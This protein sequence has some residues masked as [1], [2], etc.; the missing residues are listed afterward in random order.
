MLKSMTNNVRLLLLPLHR[1]V[2]GMELEL[3]SHVQGQPVR[4]TH[5]SARGWQPSYC[6]SWG[7][8]RSPLSLCWEEPG[9]PQG[10]PELLTHTHRAPCEPGRCSCR[11]TPAQARCT[12]PLGTESE[13][14]LQF[15]P[16][17]ML[18]VNRES[19]AKNLRPSGE[20]RANTEVSL[21]S[22]EFTE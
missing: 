11:G 7:L 16:I 15:K 20:T 14:R 8:S 21:A 22:T 3:P 9:W 1:Q 5:C 10:G 2:G 17:K 19:L 4:R 12:P 18:P 13:N 6:C